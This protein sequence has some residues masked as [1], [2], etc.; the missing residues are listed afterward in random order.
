MLIMKI[1]LGIGDLDSKY[2]F[3]QIRSTL[4]FASIF[5][6]FGIHNKS[7]ML[8]MNIIFING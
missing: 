2:R 6:K 3:G 4:K 7:N 8:I 1:V 5:M